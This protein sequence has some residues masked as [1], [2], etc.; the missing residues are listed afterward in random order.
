MSEATRHPPRAM[1]RYT[2]VLFDLFDTLVRFDRG[3]LPVVSIGGREVRSS[4]PWLYVIARSALP[5]VT[6]EAFYEAFYWSYQEAERRRAADHRE[7]AARERFGLFYARLGVSEGSAP[8]ILTERLLAAHLACL[9]GAAQAMPGRG[10]LLDWLRGRYRLAVVSNF[11]YTPTVERILGDAAIRDRF[12][13]VVVSD[14]VGWRKP[15]AVIYDVALAR[16]G[17][18]PGEC[19]FVGDRA[20]I[21]VLGAKAIGMDA[22]WLNPARTALP[23]GLPPPDFDLPDLA[24]LRPI[25][26]KSS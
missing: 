8:E 21:D 5:G 11:D 22:A 6:L 3:R 7:I 18:E 17:V 16:L 23:E 10:E 26:E 25:L 20:D 14:A 9:A 2:A 13:T 24:A 4:V 15:R 1:R 19:L 12:E